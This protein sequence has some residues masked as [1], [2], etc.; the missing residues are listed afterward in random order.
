[1]GHI[2]S[3]GKIFAL[4]HRDI[5]DIFDG[6]VVVEEKIDGSQF[7]FGVIEGQLCCRSKGKEL[8]LDAPEKL[9]LS[10]VE[11]AKRLHEACKLEPGLI[12]RCEFLSRPKHNTL[13]YERIPSQYLML[14]DVQRISDGQSMDRFLKLQ[15]AAL[16]GLEC[17]PYFILGRVHSLD[18]LIRLLETESVLG[19]CKIEGVVVK[20]YAKTMP[21]GKPMMGKF[22][23]EAFKEKHRGAWKASNPGQ[24]DFVAALGDTLRTEARWR[25]AIQHLKER[26]ELTETP[27]D[28]GKLIKEIQTDIQAEEEAA[29]KQALF[30]HFWPTINRKVIAGFPEFYKTEI[31]KPLFENHE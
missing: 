20:N 17:V 22:V 2:P 30:D 7:S 11:T 28:I 23:S 18:E 6:L 24:G 12:Y 31:A 16:L 4:G 1:M 5:A 25:K 9:F 29:I 19:G 15:A 3:Y 13:A 10:A 26:G 27:Q 21:D 8:V 14:L